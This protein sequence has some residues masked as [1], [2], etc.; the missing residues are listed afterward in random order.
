MKK[1]SILL[2]MF[3]ILVPGIVHA[4]D[5]NAVDQIT[6]EL[7]APTSKVEL[8]SGAII[9]LLNSE[10]VAYAKME[11][12]RA[13]RDARAQGVQK[14]IVV[15]LPGGDF[16]LSQ[17]ILLG[18]E[19]SGDAE[20]PIIWRGSTTNIK[21]R[22][23]GGAFL[24]D[25]T[26][27]E[28][29][30]VQTTL[31]E[32]AAGKWQFRTIWSV[33][34][35]PQPVRCRLPKSG[36]YRIEKSGEDRRTNFTWQ[37]DDLKTF[38]DLS[39]IELVFIHDWSITRCPIESLDTA[40]KT[41]RVPHQIG[42]GLAFFTIDHWEQQPRYFLENSIEFLTEPG[43]WH[44]D[45]QTGKLTYRLRKGE[46]ADSLVLVAPKLE[47]ALTIAGTAENPAKHI[48]IEHTEFGHTAAKPENEGTYWGI[49]A[50]WHHEPKQSGD[51]MEN[52]PPL[53]GAV[54]VTY[55]ENCCFDGVA[56][57]NVA[58]TGLTLGRGTTGCMLKNSQIVHC[59]GNGIMVGV[60]D[61]DQPARANTIDRCRI[62][63]A[64]QIFFGAV[65]IWI[66]FS[67]QTT[68]SNS[69]VC[70]M[71]YTGI[72]CGWQW[73]P[74][75][76]VSREQKI[77]HNDIGPCMQI[78]SDGGGIYTLGFQ[79][80][81]VLS[82]NHIHDIP[83]NAGRAESNGMFLDEGTKGFVIEDNFIHGTDKSPLRFH[84]AD[85]NVVQRN[86][87]IVPNAATPMIRY[88]STPESNIKKVDNITAVDDLEEALKKWQK[89]VSCR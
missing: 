55:A 16:Q 38:E 22:F 6:V 25:W 60:A 10:D 36:Y 44:L 68:V 86:Y 5:V 9:A 30:V 20:R 89:S 64:G 3:T 32:V 39:N 70:D 69:T 49:Q 40:T 51:G 11:A 17:P 73:N 80:D 18:P 59:G 28:P 42:N 31:P 4:I 1:R 53:K 48:H 54:N 72:S 19:D 23:S 83:L 78:L 24:S 12:R 43:E 45:R 81:S 7:P 21:T 85:T 29:G 35:G 88:N 52:V 15:Q 13:Y 87:L 77:V 14:A 46:T 66:G 2:A 76:T 33:G 84:R 65:G 71:P 47:T 56:I 57:Q 58:A 62:A 61:Q 8:P 26:E 75:P 82:G 79:P 63:S 50:T 74:Q 37:A 41:L 34:N 67:Q 27:I